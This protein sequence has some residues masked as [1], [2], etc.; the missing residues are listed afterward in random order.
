M[1]LEAK[2]EKRKIKEAKELARYEKQRNKNQ[3]KRVFTATV[4]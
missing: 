4:L 1:E 2:I 3:S